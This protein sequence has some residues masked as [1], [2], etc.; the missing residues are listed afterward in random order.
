MTQIVA[1]VLFLH[2]L[3][4]NGQFPNGPITLSNDILSI[5]LNGKAPPGQYYPCI[6]SVSVQGKEIVTPIAVGALF[7]MD[8]RSPNGD[9]YNPTQSGACS[10]DHSI[11]KAWQYNYSYVSNK[12]NGVLMGVIPRTFLS[13][14]GQ[15]T[16][17]E[18]TP[19]Y[20]NW[21]IELGNNT[22][23]FPSQ[24]MIIVQTFQKTNVSA[25]NIIKLGCE[26]PT[27]Y[28]SCDF[29]KYAYYMPKNDGEWIPMINPETGS[30]F[31]A[32]WT[33]GVM[34]DGYG[35]MRCDGSD[36]SSS[37]CAA[38]YSNMSGM[39]VAGSY[40]GNG[41]CPANMVPSSSQLISDMNVHGRT[42]IFAVGNQATVT[43][44]ILQTSK[45]IKEWG[46][47]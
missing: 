38:T 1:F 2:T 13:S 47:M 36:I 15:C 14:T 22:K 44:A 12:G 20:F 43:T 31:I 17:G 5:Q 4:I 40:N 39:T 33:K 27:V 23:T 3:F 7:Q 21:G 42:A 35:N 32:N 10:G 11:L 24:S 9:N 41:G 37:L 26:L 45:L 28:Y 30:N 18:S 16:Q 6:T 8:I 34:L 19:Y 46:D 25:P 29:A